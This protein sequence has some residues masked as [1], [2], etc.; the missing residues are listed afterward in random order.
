MAFARA[1]AD[2]RVVPGGDEYRRQ[3]RGLPE[4]VQ[5]ARR[6]T[7]ASP[8]TD[9]E[10]AACKAQLAEW[11]P[12]ALASR[13]VAEAVSSVDGADSRLYASDFYAVSSA[14]PS[15]ASAL[16][17]MIL[18]RFDRAAVHELAA[19]RER[20]LPALDAAEPPHARRLARRAACQFAGAALAAYLLRTRG[21]AAAGGAGAAGGC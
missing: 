11:L 7:R 1:T 15:A 12:A 6:A 18:P 9:A 21:V 8:P 3:A 16:D 2:A 20:L 13:W 4:L 17:L 19:A 5:A 10:A 14:F